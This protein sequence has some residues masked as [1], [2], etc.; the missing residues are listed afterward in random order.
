MPLTKRNRERLQAL[1][2]VI[3]DDGCWAIWQEVL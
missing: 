1:G 3:S 2:F